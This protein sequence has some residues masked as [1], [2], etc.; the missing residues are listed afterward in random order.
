MIATEE[1]TSFTIISFF[2]SY[3]PLQ[4]FLCPT[5]HHP[6][7]SF[8][9]FVERIRFLFHILSFPFLMCDFLPPSLLSSPFILLL[10]SSSSLQHSSSLFSP[11]DSSIA[12]LVFADTATSFEFLF[13]HRYIL[14]HLACHLFFLPLL[15]RSFLLLVFGHFFSRFLSF[16][17][18]TLFFRLFY[19]SF[20]LQVLMRLGNDKSRM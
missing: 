20:S 5:F 7:S 8:L 13:L 3:F 15:Y 9:L 10:F 1:T 12:Y 19:D 2:I 18:L 11:D 6:R 4:F 16:I 17:N 14:V